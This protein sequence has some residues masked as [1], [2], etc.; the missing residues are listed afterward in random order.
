MSIFIRLIKRSDRQLKSP[1]LYIH[2]DEK[3]FMREIRKWKK[4]LIAWSKEGYNDGTPLGRREINTCI[5]DLLRHLT[6]YYVVTTPNCGGHIRGT[7][8]LVDE[9]YAEG[10]TIKDI[11]L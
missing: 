4:D 8:R 9:E 10:D 7:F 3:E 2:N 1:V 6:A 11:L 5:V